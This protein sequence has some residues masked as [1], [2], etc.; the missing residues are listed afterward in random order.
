MSAALT[1][2]DLAGGRIAQV[3]D[4]DGLTILI[5]EKA[6]RVYQVEAWRDPEGNGPGVL[7]VSVIEGATPGR[8]VRLA[9]DRTD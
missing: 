3:L 6:G 1:A 5:V 4:A 7:D 9:E 2:R 8:P